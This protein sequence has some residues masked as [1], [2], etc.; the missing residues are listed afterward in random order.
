MKKRFTSLCLL[1]F[2][3]INVF[4]QK[5]IPF[6]YQNKSK[7]NYQ[8]KWGLMTTDKK[9]VLPPTYYTI[10]PK[11]IDATYM[12]LGKS[13]IELKTSKTVWDSTECKDVSEIK[14]NIVKIR[15]PLRG[16]VNYQPYSF[17][18]IKTKKLIAEEG[19]FAATDGFIINYS[20]GNY[21]VVDENGKAIIPIV[22]YQ[23]IKST[24]DGIFIA[25]NDY[26]STKFIYNKTGTKLNEKTFDNIDFSTSVPSIISVY[27]NIDK[28]NFIYEINFIN[29]GGKVL[30]EKLYYKNKIA[31]KFYEPFNYDR[32]GLA[33]S[34]KE[35]PLYSNKLC[36]SA[37]MVTNT[38]VLN[39]AGKKVFN[40]NDISSIDAV[41]NNLLKVTSK[42]NKTMTLL[43]F[44]G[45]IIFKTG[46]FII[47]E[48]LDKNLFFARDKT[49]GKSYFINNKGEKLVNGASFV[50]N[51]FIRCLKNKGFLIF[52]SEYNKLFFNTYDA[53]TGKSNFGEQFELE[54]GIKL[55]DISIPSGNFY[56]VKIADMNKKQYATYIY[57]I[58]GK[59]VQK[60][61]DGLWMNGDNGTYIKYTFN[62]NGEKMYIGYYDADLK[63]YSIIKE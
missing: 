39:K 27:N 44:E 29:A 41:N 61:E 63:P 60:S 32:N 28:T 11:E 57:D 34:K 36:D 22:N 1:M 2:F 19:T 59:L 8:E 53:N 25:I 58:T 17:K 48:V 12:F 42:D 21:G 47:D 6:Q 37:S 51:S 9:I 16:A 49:E 38:I 3:G 26:E 30:G 4:A 43:D 40:S 20:S 50:K 45:N 13:I 46:E 54:K 56:L 15:L 62:K 18:N 10:A 31:D 55:E 23:N 35:Y 14:G 5:L 52:K 33:I 7:W 24:A